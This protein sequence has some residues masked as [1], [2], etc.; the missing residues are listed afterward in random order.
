MTAVPLKYGIPDVALA[1]VGGGSVNPSD[2]AGHSLVVV[3]C[4]VDLAAEVH[5]LQEFA[6]HACQLES[7]DAWLITI[8]RSDAAP[9]P[10][11]GCPTASAIDPDDLAWA[12]FLDIV[13]STTL[14]RDEGSTFL[15]GR[16]GSLHHVWPGSGHAA[17]VVDELSPQMP[18]LTKSESQGPI[19][20]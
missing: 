8:H 6:Q 2:F 18:D 10:G 16:G 20:R 14:N 15:F 1:R 19:A 12:A 9:A 7:Y 17:R 13:D 4:P 3:F 11:P 5:E